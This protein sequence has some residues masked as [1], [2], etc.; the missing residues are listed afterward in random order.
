MNCQDFEINI[1]GLARG[2]LMDARERESALEHE[3]V[4]ARCAARLADE[5][6][7]T[8]GL[9][10]L[11]SEM[12]DTGAGARVESALLAAF[13]ARAG[14]VVV[15]EDASAAGPAQ[16]FAREAGQ[17]AFKNFSWSKALA[18]ASLA[19]A[20]AVAFFMLIPPDVSLPLK[21][22][23]STKAEQDAKGLSQNAGATSNNE[24]ASDSST[25]GS[26][27]G[28]QPQ[29]EPGSVDDMAAPPS[30]QRRLTPIPRATQASFEKN[31]A[32]GATTVSGTTTIKGSG[33][34]VE[35][36]G[37][38]EIATDFIPL[39]QGSQFSQAE[40]VHL[41]RVELPRYALERFGLPV[42]AEAAGGRVKADVLLGDDGVARAIRFV[43]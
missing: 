27:S 41:V 10:A 33:G 12:K 32:R 43:R 11:A 29:N 23:R 24:L 31:N 42:N 25:R 30:P 17:V 4:C 22:N 39:M 8:A 36:S 18:F 21:G 5:R 15:A 9:H 38:E 28:A 19:A 13:H 2:T 34:G 3:T 26:D 35:D 1:A 16:D 20:A 6:A 40:G 14:S 7:L 37:A